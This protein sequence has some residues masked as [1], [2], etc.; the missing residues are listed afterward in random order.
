MAIPFS[1]PIKLLRAEHPTG[2]RRT[3]RCRCKRP[4]FFRNSR[5]LACQSEL[6]YEPHWGRVLALKPGPK[7]DTWFPIGI[8][9]SASRLYQRCANLETPAA[10][11]WLVYIGRNAP[12]RPLCESCRLNRTIPDLSVPENATLWTNIEVAK[13]RVLSTLIA[14]RLPVASRLGEDPDR[15]LAFDFLRSLDGAPVMTGHADGVITLNIEE[16]DDARREA[17]RSAMLEPYRTLVGHFRH[18][19]GHY[20]WYRLI[21][22]SP[23]LNNFRELFGDETADYGAALQKH[24]EQGAPADWLGKFVSAYASSHPWEDW[25]ETWAHY[26]HMIDSLATAASFGLKPESGDLRFDPF[27]REALYRP[28]DPRASTFLTFLN[29]WIELTAVV[30]EFSRSMGQHDFY[31]FALPRAAVGKLQFIHMVIGAV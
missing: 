15:G 22:E 23:W 24:H 30:N 28:D 21:A 5:C 12:G 20:Y 17:I 2:L 9:N 1:F 29:H 10:C 6:G 31:P 26:L 25:A 13:R 8:R 18:E 27:P 11:N 7:P 4:V 14:L 3:Y 19:L 16:A